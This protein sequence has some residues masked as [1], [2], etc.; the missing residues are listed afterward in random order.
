MSADRLRSA[1]VQAINE[2]E[3][4]HRAD[5][6]LQ[7]RGGCVICWPRDGRWPCTSR[8]IATDLQIALALPAEGDDE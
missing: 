4:E 3:N 7:G 8:M 2:L 6:R 1:V 5:D